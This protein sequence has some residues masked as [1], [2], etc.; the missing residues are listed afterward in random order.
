MAKQTFKIEGVYIV[1]E[2]TPIGHKVQTFGTGYYAVDVEGTLSEA[3]DFGLFT[4]ME[5]GLISVEAYHRHT[6]KDKDLSGF[7]ESFA[8]K[9]KKTEKGHVFENGMW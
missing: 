3:L 6:K 7:L 2:K 9:L 5:K 1:V 4:L 8:K